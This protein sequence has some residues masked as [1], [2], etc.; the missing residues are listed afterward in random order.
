M[1]Q[2][3]R[4]RVSLDEVSFDESLNVSVPFPENENPDFDPYLSDLIL[5]LRLIPLEFIQL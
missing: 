3:F 5:S 4:M 2:K 1:I